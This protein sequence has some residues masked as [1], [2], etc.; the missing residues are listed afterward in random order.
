[1]NSRFSKTFATS[2]IVEELAGIIFGTELLEGTITRSL[3]GKAIHLGPT[4]RT[5]VLEGQG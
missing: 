3:L 1:V 4:A 5:P 2:T